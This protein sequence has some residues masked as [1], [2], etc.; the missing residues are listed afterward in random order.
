LIGE[1][2]RLKSGILTNNV[3]INL[4]QRYAKKDK[5]LN[6]QLG[7]NGNNNIKLKTEIS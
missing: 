4:L 5:E 1:S 2:E 3:N 7:N 6:T